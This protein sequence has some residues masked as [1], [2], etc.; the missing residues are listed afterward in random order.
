MQSKILPLLEFAEVNAWHRF[1][2]NSLVRAEI[3]DYINR[4]KFTAQL[5]TRGGSC[6]DDG[7]FSIDV[8]SYHPPFASQP[9]LILIG[10]MGPLAGAR[11]CE[12]A[13]EYFA[14]CREVVLYQACS[15]PNRVEAMNRPDRIIQGLPLQ[16]YLV[17]AVSHAIAQSYEYLSGNLS[18][19]TVIL[20]CNAVHYFLPQIQANVC[21]K[22]SAIAQ[23]LQYISLVE[24]VASQLKRKNLHKPL[25]LAT[26]A[27]L[28]GRVYHN[29][30][31]QWGIECQQLSAFA[32]N[33]LMNA[34]YRGVKAFDR[35]YTCRQVEELFR[36]L[37]AIPENKGVLH[38]DVSINCD[39]IIAGCT[40]VP[41]LLNWVREQTKYA[42]IQ[43][44][45]N[46]IH[47]VDPVLSAFEEVEFLSAPR[48]PEAG[49]RA[50]LIG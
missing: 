15:I 37:L 45:L 29:A 27:T 26:S 18:R 10:G 39:C 6:P 20:L 8:F 22:H 9:P 3:S 13:C 38:S 28:K 40:E 48:L 7:D 36:G 11:G 16:Q 5:Q 24:A 33:M 1:T 4:L 31:E 30:L 25:L 32:Q 19:C 43:Q 21:K 2:D 46:R 42:E 41:I 44:F 14:D 23:S 34:I 47:I 49:L 17:E 50:S 12:L 35:D